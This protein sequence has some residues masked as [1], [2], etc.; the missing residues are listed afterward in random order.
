MSEKQEMLNLLL[1]TD[2]LN[3]AEDWASSLRQKRYA[4][5][6]TRADKLADV[7]RE[8]AKHQIDLLIIA[9]GL[10]DAKISDITHYIAEV[11]KDIPCLA[12]VSEAD[13]TKGAALYK[14][15][16][17]VIIASQETD[18][19]VFAVERELASLRA[20]RQVRK[21]E[22]ALQESEKRERLLLA[23]SDKA[24]AYIHEGMHVSANSVY[25]TLFGYQDESELAGLPLLDMV[26]ANEQAGLKTQFRIFSEAGGND[27]LQLEM[28]CVREDGSEFL[29]QL[30]L[31]H[32]RFEGEA[33]IQASWAPQ[34]VEDN[35]EI[36]ASAAAKVVNKEPKQEE[37]K[38]TK[39]PVEA[40][41][42]EERQ[43]WKKRLQTALQTDDFKLLYQPIVGLHG[44]EQVMYEVLLRYVDG[45]GELKSS[46]EF[47]AVAKA[48]GLMIDIDKWFVNRALDILA[49][50]T[51]AENMSF[52]IKLSEQMMSSAQDI[53][54]LQTTLSEHKV[55]G[56]QLV[57][58]IGEVFAMKHVDKV[59]PFIEALKQEGCRFCLADFGTDP[60]LSRSLHS[61]D[62]DFFKIN[63]EFVRTMMSKKS[64]QKSVKT[65]AEMIKLGG[66]VG[67][68]EQVEDAQSM[69]VLWGFGVDYAQGNYMQPPTDQ[70]NYDFGDE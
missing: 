15:A 69:A 51:A 40:S 6:E 7:E 57:F 44:V 31:R 19:L 52:F 23:H 62:V 53:A 32:A 20:R 3:Q 45:A 38:Q 13:Q 47:G 4:I 59:R 17:Q 70:M 41:A 33:C 65:I 5:Q 14:E 66:K 36:V 18:W 39:Q 8:I 25:T 24:I 68:A 43:E 49:G 28:Q 21:L 11:G 30:A 46:A 58:E 26:V 63:G 61:L 64:S 29:A 35:Q 2:S 67:I 22:V 56:S 50:E 27:V 42:Q 1:V 10:E 37:S 54:W 34:L 16:V 12:V 55:A 9:D 48:S 60:D